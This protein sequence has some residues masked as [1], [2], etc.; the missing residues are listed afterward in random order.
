MI[1]S[2]ILVVNVLPGSSLKNRFEKYVYSRQI[3]IEE[4]FRYGTSGHL[5]FSGSAGFHSN[6][7]IKIRLV[8]LNDLQTEI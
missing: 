2:L 3:F 6:S 7:C 1:V 5:S 4:R 8:L